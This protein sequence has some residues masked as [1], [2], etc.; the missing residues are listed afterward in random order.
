MGNSVPFDISRRR[1]LEGAV[2]QA[3]RIA[4]NLPDTADKRE[5]A[6]YIMELEE[7]LRLVGDPEAEEPLDL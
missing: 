4:A 7:K 2:A 3:R 1:R 5:M 6:R